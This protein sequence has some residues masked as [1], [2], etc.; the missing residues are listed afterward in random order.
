ME[1][2]WAMLAAALRTFPQRTGMLATVAR[3]NQGLQSRKQLVPVLWLSL[4]MITA[5]ARR[6]AASRHMSLASHAA[7][8]I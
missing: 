6:L 8:A 2:G 4:L 3:P 1:S 5:T 7:P